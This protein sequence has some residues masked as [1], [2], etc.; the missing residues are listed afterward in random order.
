MGFNKDWVAYVGPFNFPWGQ[1]GSRRVYGNAMSLVE[2][3]YDVIVA[4]GDAPSA[5]KTFPSAR[6]EGAT[7]TYLGV[8]EIP[9]SGGYLGKLWQ[10]LINCGVRT[11]N[12]LS[13]QPVKPKYVVI[14]GGLAAFS[15]HGADRIMCLLLLML[16]NG[17]T[18]HKCLVVDLVLFMSVQ[19]W[20]FMAC[21]L[22]LMVSSR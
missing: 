6:N 11:V 16:S 8:G 14:Y 7:L 10:H 5:L 18:R 4:S 1:A 9:L 21:I 20:R 3:G 12:W 15:W 13:E 2:A 17:M 19:T 22:V